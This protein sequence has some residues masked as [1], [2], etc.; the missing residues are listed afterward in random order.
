MKA[1]LVAGLALLAV[2]GCASTS[3][4]TGA[5]PG[6]R[7]A[8]ASASTTAPAS[9]A[10]GKG[11]SGSWNVTFVEPPLTDIHPSGTSLETIVVNRDGTV[12]TYTFAGAVARA[13]YINTP[14]GVAEGTWAADGTMT[15]TFDLSCTSSGDVVDTQRIPGHTKPLSVNLGA[16]PSAC[17]DGHM[18][19][20]GYA[21]AF[22]HNGHWSFTVVKA[23]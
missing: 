7:P 5:S 10:T 17:S 13:E 3:T 11:T 4:P 12:D 9:S 1:S 18:N 19:A 16:M 20:L 6:G 21:R 2:A 23:G 15:G 14:G 8:S 22:A